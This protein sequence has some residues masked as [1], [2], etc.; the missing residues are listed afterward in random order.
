MVNRLAQ[1]GEL[2]VLQ[3]RHVDRAIARRVRP[4]RRHRGNFAP[5][6]DIEDI[7]GDGKNWR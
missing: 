5:L 2:V 7:A 4:R 6:I 1:S 3:N